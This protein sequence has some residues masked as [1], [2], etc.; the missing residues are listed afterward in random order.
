MKLLKI[1]LYHCRLTL[2]FPNFCAVFCIECFPM[3]KFAK[4]IG[5]LPEDH[6]HGLRGGNILWEVKFCSYANSM[7]HR[8]H[9][10]FLQT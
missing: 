8:T 4:P 3:S 6:Q 5:S 7:N 2:V 10:K 9:F 1:V